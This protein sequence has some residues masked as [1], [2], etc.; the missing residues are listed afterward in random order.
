MAA[1]RPQRGRLRPDRRRDRSTY[2][3]A[4]EDN[5]H[6]LRVQVTATNS[7]GTS[8]PAYSLPTA[9]ILPSPGRR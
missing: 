3:V 2:V 9:A 5:G 6:K 1:L 8:L 4:A 7:L